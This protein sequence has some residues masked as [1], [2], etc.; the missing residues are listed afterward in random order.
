[1]EDDTVY[2]DVIKLSNGLYELRKIQ[3]N[4]EMKVFSDDN[5]I[6]IFQNALMKIITEIYNEVIQVSNLTFPNF[7]SICSYELRNL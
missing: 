3:K 4:M 6:G 1:M 7:D 5:S 2:N